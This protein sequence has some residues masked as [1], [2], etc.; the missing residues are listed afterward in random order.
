MNNLPQKYENNVFSKIASFFRKIFGTR[1]KKSEIINNKTQNETPDKSL[2]LAIDNSIN[3]MKQISKQK[4]LKEDILG[5]VMKNP[6]TVDKLSQKQLKSLDKMLDEEIDKNNKEIEK[7]K[8][9]YEK[10]V[11]T[12]S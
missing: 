3:E 1:V 7:L 6:V 8:Q 5:I 4:N 2:K 10:L 9:K 12:V 11:S